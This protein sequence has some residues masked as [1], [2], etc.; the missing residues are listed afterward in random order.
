MYGLRRLS[1]VDIYTYLLMDSYYCA[2][3]KSCSEN[4]SS[5]DYEIKVNSINDASKICEDLKKSY[6]K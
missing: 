4:K 6:R 5:N 3:I 2:E 1:R